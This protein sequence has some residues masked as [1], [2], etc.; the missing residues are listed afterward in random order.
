MIEDNIESLLALA[1][2]SALD[3]GE[4]IQ[5]GASRRSTLNV[6]EKGMHDYVSEIDR[7]A[8][9][10]VRRHIRSHF[11]DHNIL[12]EEFGT[13]KDS[14]SDYQWIIDP[15][16]GTTNFV[17]GIPHYAVSIAVQYRSKIVVGVVYDPVKREL[18]SALKG[19]GSQLNDVPIQA[20]GI[21][22]IRGALL[23]TGVPFSGEQLR[24]ISKFTETMV[25]LLNEQTSGIRRLGAAALDLAYVAA[26]RY[27]GFWE[28]SLKPWDIAAGTL[29]VREAGGIVTNFDGENDCLSCGNIVAAASGAHSAML[30]SV[31]KAY[32]S[33]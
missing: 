14:G 13:S 29:L 9:E 32:T 6:E 15:L 22:H 27:D 16:D 7:G 26:G 5:E 33:I 11:P 12:G 20:S 2:Q 28:A 19:E 31:Q 1:K 10:I 25:S 18:F 24:D 17:R 3:A 23:A 21:P 8:E 30:R 4:F